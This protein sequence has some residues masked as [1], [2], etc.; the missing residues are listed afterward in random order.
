MHPFYNDHTA[1]GALLAMF[2]PVVAGLALNK[3]RSKFSRITAVV[4][5]VIFVVALGLSY[6]RASW[7]SVVIAIGV[8]TLML[9]KIRLRTIF[10]GIIALIGLLVINQTRVIMKLERNDKVVSQDLTSEIQSISNISSDASNRERINRWSCAYRMFLDKPFFGF[11]P[12]T[13]AFK[14]APY[15][16]AAQRTIISTNLGNGGNAHSEYLGPLAEQ[17]LLGMLG[18]M[19]LAVGVFILSFNLYYK[20]EDK[21]MKIVVMSVFLGLITYFVHGFMNNFLDTDKA[22]VPF[23]GFIGI[24]VTIDLQ[25]RGVFLW[26][27]K[28]PTSVSGS[29]KV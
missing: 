4:L 7:V 13:Y 20:L 18:F 3:Y 10:I 26:K 8:M 29:L 19:A 6:S 24:L 23:W 9:F 14:Y 11:G 21:E 17:G 5:F 28:E 16:I 12:G 27:D 1:Y 22:A 15:Q 2:V 25:R